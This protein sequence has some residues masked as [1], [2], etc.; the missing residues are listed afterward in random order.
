MSYEQQAGRAK[1]RARVSSTCPFCQTGIEA[2]AKEIR[3]YDCG[4]R[5]NLFGNPEYLRRCQ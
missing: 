1:R 3:Y 5:V 4:T 2:D